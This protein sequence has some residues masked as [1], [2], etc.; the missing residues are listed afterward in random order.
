[1]P[2]TRNVAPREGPGIPDEDRTSVKRVIES[3]ERFE[4]GIGQNFRENNEKWYRQYRGFRQ[5]ADAW[6]QGT[7][8]DRDAMIYDAK[9]NWGA[10]LHIPMSFRTIETIVPKAIA[11]APKLLV[12]PRDEQW[13]ENVESVRLLMDRQQEQI[14][15]D[16]YLQAVMRAGRIYGLGVGKTYWR[17]ESTNRRRAERRVFSRGFKVGRLQEEVTFDDPMFEDVDVFDFGWDPAGHDMRSC[18]WVYHRIWMSTEAVVKRIQSKL[19]QTA[20]AQSLNA[21]DIEGMGS[22]EE[23]SD[24]WQQRMEASSMGNF[25]RE[26]LALAG[27][28][29]HELIEF[30]DGE[31][32]LTVLDR[33]VLV[34]DAENPCCGMFPFQI[35]RPVPLQKQMVGI[36]DLEPLEHLQRELDTLRSQ[37]RD[38]VTIALCAGYAFDDGTIK[39]DELTIGPNTLIPVNGPPGESLMPLAIKDVPGSG[40]QE[41]AAIINNIEAVSGLQDA[42]NPQPGS[43]HEDTATGAMLNQA[44]LSQRIQLGSR[45]F[46]IEVAREACRSW[47]YLNQRMILTQRPNMMLPPE[48]MSREEAHEAGVWRQY[49]IGPGELMGEYEIMPEGGS[50]AARN[51]PQD[52]A[53]AAQLL[54]QYGQHPLI[55]PRKVLEASLRLMGVKHPQGWLKAERPVVPK[56]ATDLL[57][58]VVDPGLVH[59]AIA[60]AEAVQE[61]GEAGP[62]PDEVTAAMGAEGSA[63]GGPG[64]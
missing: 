56:L 46:E 64:P 24:V 19:W 62:S 54:N 40:W 37:R 25:G 32:V 2:E 6:T 36:G 38:M 35:Y 33:E 12:E 4:K 29:I 8:N 48:G 5:F 10:H 11:Q 18:E 28:H 27:E 49:K 30:H 16:L 47:L 7:K 41:E 51:V 26:G 63:N 1:M 31:R 42:L 17:R 3:V 52:R 50:M 59:R 57:E 9:R 53:D 13:R 23:Y 15:I 44:A 58:R 61:G 14:N 39:A 34:Q 45:R 55:E 22:N 21:E 20:S 43:A 60:K